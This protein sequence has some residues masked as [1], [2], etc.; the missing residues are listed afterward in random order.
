MRHTL[1]RSRT[2]G[3]AAVLALLLPLAACGDGTDD[4]GT[5]A[6]ESSEPS[7]SSPDSSSETP[8]VTPTVT[9]GAEGPVPV[10]GTA[11]VET[12]VVVAGP[13]AGGEVSPLAFPL[14]TR[15]A[16]R[17]FTSGLEAGLGDEV[18]KA[19]RG[20]DAGDGTL[21]WGTIAAVGCEGPTA[22]RIDAG[23]AGYEVTPTMPKS[24]VQCLVPVTYVVVFA[25]PT[26]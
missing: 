18:T 26:A 12:A 7:P 23:E 6:T 25:A 20:L 2:A 4:G 11:G 9:P 16:R 1:R 15:Q 17:D 13:E 14:D 24:T 22:V 5:T 21:P 8:S 10:T 19:V 3:P